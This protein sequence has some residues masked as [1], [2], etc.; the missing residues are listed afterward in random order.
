MAGKRGKPKS[1]AERRADKIKPLVEG[2]NVEDYRHQ[3]KRKNIPSSGQADY[4]TTPVE[5]KTYKYDPHLDPQLHWAGKAERLSFDVDTV[6]L[7]IH[8]RISTQA[9]LRAIRSKAVQRTLF[10]D[11]SEDLKPGQ[12]VEFY[13]HDM[14]WTNR[15]ILGDSLVVMN[16]LLERENMSGKVQMIYIDPPYGIRYNSNFQPAI[17]KRDAK[18]GADTTL[19]REPE[20]VRAYRD[21]WELGVHS[22]LT[23]LRDRLFLARELLAATGSCFVQ[24][25]EENLHRVRLLMDEIFGAEN[26][27]A[28]IPYKTTT[29]RTSDL[30]PSLCDFLVWYTKD[31]SQVKYHQLFVERDF[32]EDIRGEFKFLALDEKKFRKLT[33]DEI[34]NPAKIDRTKVFRTNSAV[35][36]GVRPNTTGSFEAGGITYDSGP[37][38]NWMTTI[39]G[40]KN[41]AKQGRLIPT[42]S[43]SRMYKQY[44]VDFPFI[45]L[46][47][48]WMDVRSEQNKAYVVQ[49]AERVIE[50]CIVMVTD[51]GDLVLDI[52]CGS[53]TTAACAE[54]W[55][56]RWIT[57]DTSRVALS[58]ARQR[59]MTSRFPF[60]KLQNPSLGVRG[61]FNYEVATHVTLRSL[62]KDDSPKRETLYDRPLE[63]VG[64]VR[65]SGPFTVEAIPR[66]TLVDGSS[67]NANVANAEASITN[68]I[69]LMRKDGLT[70]KNDKRLKFVRLTP[71]TGGVIHG[72]GEAEQDGKPIRVA[73]SVGPMHGPVTVDQVQ[74]AIQERPSDAQLLV[75]AGFA[76]DAEARALLDKRPPK[77]LQVQFAHIAPDILVGDLLK[78]KR[79]DQLF[80]VFG[81][82]DTRLEKK[83]DKY[84]LSV[85][86]LD[87]YDPT[88]GK[89]ESTSGERELE[90]QVAA[91]FL[92]TNYD[93]STF[94]VCQAFFP[95]KGVNAWE[96]IARALKATISEDKWEQLSGLT[97][98][99]FEAG[100]Q[101]RIAVKVIDHRGNEIVRVMDL[102]GA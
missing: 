88:T 20:M 49:T 47:N 38:S 10:N 15:L 57:T 101:K 33:Q 58:L 60:Y 91:W 5:K 70:F 75:L 67:G 76:F 56:R 82:V 19:T 41:V 29:G 32:E 79:N 64:M 8:E 73:V 25:S 77:H 83:G 66:F 43:P 24:I 92:D 13:K 45:P 98:V 84:T 30:I 3:D 35:A 68:I 14:G 44:W 36:P 86:G 97:S 85:T 2:E 23:Y 87:L 16:S 12:R 9:I 96:K 78:T 26:F 31:K 34:A 17:N 61:G 94:L 51:P 54:K 81:D 69:E 90:A 28:I 6:S 4:D 63:E 22:Y 89:V 93:R 46:T 74:A 59:I 50:R 1:Q 40:M 71:M 102:K 42:N 55:G 72:E 80:T 62:G 37:A 21:T 95:A 99:P 65:V 18:D 39:P 52:T 7:H 27:A 11:P 100:D 53:G 48:A